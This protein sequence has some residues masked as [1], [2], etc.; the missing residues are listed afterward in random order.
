MWAGGT[1]GKKD[2]LYRKE[3]A[4]EN[5]VARCC[6]YT[7][8]M[9][10][11]EIWTHFSALY[12]CLLALF[13]QQRRQLSCPMCLGSQVSL[14]QTEP[15]W[16]LREPCQNSRLYYRWINMM[17]KRRLIFSSKCHCWDHFVD[18]VSSLVFPSSG[19]I[20][21]ILEWAQWTATKVFKQL[22][23]RVCMTD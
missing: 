7:K 6:G 13:W 16:L 12:I 17:R 20:F 1:S 18:A 15:Q 11:K 5:R 21:G 22:E 9:L 10:N 8:G 19:K 23:N 14:E 2:F 3:I 4:K